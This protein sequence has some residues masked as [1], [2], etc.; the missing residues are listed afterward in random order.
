MIAGLIGV[1]LPTIL[2]LSV[3]DIAVMSHLSL[4]FCIL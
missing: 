2:Q 1:P 3:Q 4:G